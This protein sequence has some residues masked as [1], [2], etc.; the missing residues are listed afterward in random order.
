MANYIKDVAPGVDTIAQSTY[1]AVAKQEQ[2]RMDTLI[3]S[4]GDENP[5][6][7]WQEMGREMTNHCTVVRYNDKLDGLIANMRDYKER[8]KRVKLSDTGM[9]TNQNL[10]FARAVRDMI[11]MAEGIAKAARMR[12]ESRGAHY[13]PDFPERDDAN[14]LKSTVVT[15][16][17]AKDEAFVEWGPIDTSLIPPRLRTYGKVE[18][19]KE[20]AE[21]E[22]AKAKVKVEAEK[23]DRELAAV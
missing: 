9:W 1:D 14:Y 3:S 11:A 19:K 7:L 22:K 4:D 12:D 8:Y 13:K 20:E 18:E 17:A 10:S 5:Y 15:Y 21:V 23:K 16:D 6:E 2:D